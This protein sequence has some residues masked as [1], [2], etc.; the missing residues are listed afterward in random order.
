MSN[1]RI[2]LW[3]RALALVFFKA[4]NQEKKEFIA[5]WANEMFANLKWSY[6]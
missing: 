1:T 5:V 3:H 2:I 4:R 6:D